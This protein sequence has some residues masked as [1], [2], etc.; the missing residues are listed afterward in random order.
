M[1]I[2]D[3]NVA[4]Q[5]ARKI[6]RAVAR[7]PKDLR[8]DGIES[9]E[10]AWKWRTSLQFIL[11]FVRKRPPTSSLGGAVS[12]MAQAFERLDA[13]EQLLLILKS[14]ADA[15]WDFLATVFQAPTESLQFRY[16]STLLEIAERMGHPLRRCSH[17]SIPDRT[18]SDCQQLDAFLH[19]VNPWIRNQLGE[20]AP[21]S[22][23]TAS[24]SSTLARTRRWW[25][26]APWF[27]R[28]SVEGAVVSLGIMMIVA[29]VPKLRSI[30]EKTVAHKLESYNFSSDFSG[31]F[32]GNFS[33]ERAGDARRS[34][35]QAGESTAAGD[36]GDE[37]DPHALDLEPTGQTIDDKDVTVGENEV[38]R[39]NIKTDSPK[40]VRLKIE[41]VLAKFS[42]PQDSP[43][44]RGIQAPGG[45]QY[46]LAFP[47]EKV[48]PFKN[49]ISTLSLVGTS[50]ASFTWFKNKS[51]KKIPA[52]STSVIVWVYQI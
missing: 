11:P 40:D 31:D 29:W 37:A 15:T 26:F 20:T 50:G 46:I 23:P 38:W 17:R 28:T 18:C 33:G 39:L 52:G 47:I 16:R 34:V 45:V 25:Q 27:V 43:E 42:I 51:K 5:V 4:R 49:E 30:Y 12:P 10:A 36:A 1:V 19:T 48:I 2:P 6:E 9:L 32:S 44:S 41:Q 35:P 21:T 24:K 8:F 3:V 22:E 7:K 13:E 14:E